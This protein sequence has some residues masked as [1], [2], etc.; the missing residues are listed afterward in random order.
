[1]S[2]CFQENLILYIKRF[3][4]KI[5]YTNFHKNELQFDLSYMYNFRSTD[6]MILIILYT[7]A[8][9]KKNVEN[10]FKKKITSGLFKIILIE[11]LYNTFLKVYFYVTI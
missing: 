9:H 8:T 11:H 3:S 4:I 5:F 10:I 7:I 2:E 6:V 1:M